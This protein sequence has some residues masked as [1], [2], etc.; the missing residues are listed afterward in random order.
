M[1]RLRLVI[2]VL[3]LAGCV[4]LVPQPEPS[5]PAPQPRPDVRPEPLPTG[6]WALDRDTTFEALARWIEAGK[7]DSTDRLLKVCARTIGENGLTFPADY[8]LTM[9]QFL[10]AGNVPLTADL[11]RDAVR[12]LRGFKSAK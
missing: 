1:T 4:K 12:K 3:A 2:A 10:D 5:S 8:D 9:K 11:Q 6:G 7:C